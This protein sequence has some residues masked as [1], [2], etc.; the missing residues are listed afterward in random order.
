MYMSCVPAHDYEELRQSLP[1]LRASLIP[2]IVEHPITCWSRDR[3]LCLADQHAGQRRSTLFCPR[4]ESGSES[5]P[6]RAGDAAVA[7]DIERQAPSDAVAVRSD[8]Y[9]DGGD[10]VA[11][12]D[13]VFVTPAV[14]KANLQRTVQSE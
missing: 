10:F 4:A 9:F 3:W 8:L 5:W 2:V 6:Q 7:F 11:D 14:L 12:A 1:T 13:I